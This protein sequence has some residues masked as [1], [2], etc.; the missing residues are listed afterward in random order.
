M[1][2]SHEFSIEL[3]NPS[4]ANYEIKMVMFAVDNFRRD[5]HTPIK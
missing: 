5:L 1:Y 4:D 2:R 3:P